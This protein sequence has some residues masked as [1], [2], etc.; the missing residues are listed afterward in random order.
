MMLVWQVWADA[1]ACQQHHAKKQS[2]LNEHLMTSNCGLYSYF[3]VSNT[4]WTGP[5]RDDHITFL[6]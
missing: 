5:G 6:D 3:A 1:Q 2:I 4:E